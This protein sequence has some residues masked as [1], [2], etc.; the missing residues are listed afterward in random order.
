[1]I[2]FQKISYRN[3]LSTGNVCNVVDLNSHSSTLITGKNGEGKSTILDALTYVLFGKPFRNINKPQLINSI[4]QK[5]LLVEIDF[6]IAGKN[7]TVKRGMKPNI[8]QIFCEGKLLNEEADTRDYQKI[9]EQQILK[10]NYKSFTQVVILGSATFVPFMQLPAQRRREIIEDILD[11]K[12]FSNMNVLLK[13]KTITLKDNISKIENDIQTHKIKIEAQKKLIEVLESSKKTVTDSILQKI[14]KNNQ[15]IITSQEIIDLNNKEIAELLETKKKYS[16]V[17]SAI[18]QADSMQVKFQTVLNSRKKDIEF[19]N[20]NDKCPRCSQDITDEFKSVV[21]DGLKAK[22]L[23]QE[24]KIEELSNVYTKLNSQLQKLQDIDNRISLKNSE[25]TTQNHTISLLNRTNMQ[26]NHELESNK[27]DN[28]DID[29]ETGKLTDYNNES[30]SLMD[31]KVKL[32]E[33]KQLYDVAFNLLKDTGIKTAIIKEYLPVIN[34]L[35]NKYLAVMDFYAKFELDETF[36]EVIKSRNRDIFSYNSFSEGEKR[37]IDISILLTWRQVAKMKNSANTNLLIMDE[38]MDGNLDT[39]S[40]ELLC[41]ILSDITKQANTNVFIISHREN[42][43]S[44]MF[45]NTIRAKKVNEFTI[46]E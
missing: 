46:L 22:I 37:K 45:D 30:I 40:L 43:G 3:F 25:I 36:Q 6:Q 21:V 15:A 7:Y 12:V 14:E 41:S 17:T 5:N 11:I 28:N 26:L 27:R 4:N 33:T 32:F 23:E 18:Q 9:L 42:A 24:R 2:I 31:K 34:K 1:M 16:N 13:E 10:L 35:I 8:F 19:F 20:T 39:G 38:V 29:V 44:E